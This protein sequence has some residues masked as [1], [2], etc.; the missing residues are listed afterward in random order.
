M[1]V[2]SLKP[3]RTVAPVAEPI[4]LAEAKAHLRVDASD[5]DDLITALI[6]A[7]TASLDGW[8]GRLGRCLVTQTWRQ[9]YVGFPQ[10]GVLR[11]P[12][13]DVQSVSVSYVDETGASQTLATSIYHVVD[14]AIG[15]ACVRDPD[16]TWP[17]TDDRPISVSVTLVAGFGLAAAVPAPIKAAIKLMVGD[18]YA[19]RETVAGGSYAS[20]PMSMTVQNLLAPYRRSGIV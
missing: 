2:F 4:S 16:A 8:S 5:E 6:Q 17:E 10:G 13:P 7:A 20:I 15:A 11:L 14:D 19:H 9:D 1:N 3:V 18:L 12:F